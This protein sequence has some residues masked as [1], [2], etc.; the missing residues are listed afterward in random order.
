MLLRIKTNNTWL[1]YLIDAE[2]HW[3]ENNWTNTGTGQI[4]TYTDL[5]DHGYPSLSI[6]GKQT[7]QMWLKPLK[8]TSLF[9]ESLL[10]PGSVS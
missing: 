8:N 1:R 4:K 6:Q 2:G 5:E 10:H 3:H 9:S 7:D